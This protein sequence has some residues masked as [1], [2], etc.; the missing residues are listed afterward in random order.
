MEFHGYAKYPKE[1]KTPSVHRL[2]DLGSSIE[3]HTIRQFEKIRDLFS[4]KYKQQT[5]SFRRF[6]AQNPKHSHL[7]EGSLDMV[8]WSKDHRGV[9]DVKSKN[10]RYDFRSRKMKWDST[11]EQLSSM[12]TV[13][14]FGTDAYWVD[15]LPAFLDELNDPFFAGNFL[16]LN[17]YA[18]NP[19][20]VERGINHASVIQYNKND[21]RMREV[22]FR[23]S[24]ELYEKTLTK[25]GNV[26]A[27]VD[28]Q[29]DESASRDFPEGSFKCRYCPFQVQCWGRKSGG[30]K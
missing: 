16:Q 18:L 29:S 1:L 17:L 8:F 12:S 10:D 14:V 27:A 19:F 22:R 6:E 4:V 2:L 26:I 20:L 28:A 9:A 11:T 15:N 3:Y 24:V 13:E 21:S 25:Y 23:P 7:L 5:L 30:R